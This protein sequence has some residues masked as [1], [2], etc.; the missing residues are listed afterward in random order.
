MIES[1]QRRY[2]ASQEIPRELIESAEEFFIS[3]F[4]FAPG[5][6]N[7]LNKL[8]ELMRGGRISS[9]QLKEALKRLYEKSVEISEK[10]A[11]GA[12]KAALERKEKLCAEIGRASCRERV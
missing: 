11:L 10:N 6:A 2:K 7:R 1:L 5:R 8:R 4:E 3:S 9:L 12:L